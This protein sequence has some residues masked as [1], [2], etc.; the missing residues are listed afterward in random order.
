[1]TPVPLSLYIHFPWCVHKC[2]YCDFN[3]HTATET[4]PE[5]LYI[6]ALIR[7][8]EQELPHIWGRRLH[9]IFIGGG[10]PS[11]ISPEGMQT[12]L[13]HIQ[14]LLPMRPNMEITMEANPGTFEQDRFSG[15]LEAGITRLSLGI[16]SFNPQ[17]LKSLERIH[18]HQEAQ[19]AFITSQA[20]GFNNINLDLMFGLPKQSMEDALADLQQ[21]IDHQPQHISWYELTLEPNTLFHHNPPPLP[22]PD[23]VAEMQERGL[24]LLKEAGY[25][26]Y[27]VSAYAKPGKRCQHNLNYWEFG[28]YMGIGAG[29]HGKYTQ[30]GHITRYAKIKHPRDYIDAAMNNQ[31]RSS[32]SSLSDQ[33][34]L[35]EFMLNAL[36]LKE[37][38][39][40]TL[41]YE[42][43]HL[44]ES[45]V[46]PQL[47]SAQAKGLLLADNQRIATTEKGWIYLNQTI[48]AF[49]TAT[50]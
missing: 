30:D 32:S 14:Q 41:L 31:A 10:T 25:S 1:M 28:D 24:T 42:R 4:L 44:N 18:D 12:L 3:S 35:F 17:Y 23:T 2:P 13:T 50:H 20:V 45:F 7:D 11:L 46:E 37:G 9:T 48:E 21:A 39:P 34:K 29:A 38:V 36:R 15:Y 27:E 16:Q 26:R 47:M 49:L 19:T 33:D 5:D 43:T 6:Q 8:L 22:D 40:K